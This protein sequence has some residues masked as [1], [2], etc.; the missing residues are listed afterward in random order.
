MEQ[1]ERTYLEDLKVI[2]RRRLQILERKKA[3][4][5]INTPPEIEIEI[6]D[7][8]QSIKDIDDRLHRTRAVPVDL[9]SYTAIAPRDSTTI[10]LD[11]TAHFSGGVASEQIWKQHLIPDLYNLYKRVSESSAQPALVLR[12]RATIA[13]AVAFG[14]V[15]PHSSGIDLW[16]EQRTDDR[17]VQWWAA[18]EDTP[19]IVGHL[20]NELPS[21]IACDG[22]GTDTLIEVA[23]AQDIGTAV[24]QWRQAQPYRFADHIRFVPNIGSDRTSVPDAA[25]ALAMA[26]QIAAACVAAHAARPTGTIHLIVSAPFALAVMIG[27][28]LNACGVIQCHE[29]NREGKTYTPAWKMTV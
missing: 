5:G 3:H 7:I 13:S 28:K 19:T 8:T 20:L 17:E 23:V 2:H 14:A 26:R 12:Q 16:I 11:W 29:F 25:H 18:Q 10:Q 4:F 22:D 6:E 15:F 27:R 9:L 24:M 21:P 1:E